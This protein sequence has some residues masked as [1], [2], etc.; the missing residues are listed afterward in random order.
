MRCV[1]MRHKKPID[2]KIP[3]TPTNI[4]K[5]FN[6]E[7]ALSLFKTAHQDNMRAS[8]VLKIHTNKKG[9][10][11][12]SQLTRVKLMMRI[13]T[14]TISIIFMLLKI[15]LFSFFII[16]HCIIVCRPTPLYKRN[17]EQVLQYNSTKYINPASK[18]VCAKFEPNRQPIMLKRYMLNLQ[19]QQAE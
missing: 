9:L 2:L 1:V 18:A 8:V 7:Y 12:P 14:P 4:Q 5:I 10:L 17:C 3:T 13:I 15:S 16:F 19:S 11:G 6:V